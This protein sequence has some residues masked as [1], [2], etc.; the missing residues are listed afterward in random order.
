MPAKPTTHD[1]YIA[2]LSADHRVI[3]ETLR[4]TIQAAAPAAVECISYNIPAF[5]LNG[6]VVIFYGAARSHYALYAID[7]AVLEANKE[8]VQA[9]DTSGKGTLRFPWDKPLP[10]KLLSKLVKA[11]VAAMTPK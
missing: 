6:K 8:E 5:R 4:R 10:T 1:E 3:L 2:A 11:V 7:N 9:Y